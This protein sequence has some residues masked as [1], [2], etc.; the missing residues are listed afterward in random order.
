MSES[1]NTKA[2]APTLSGVAALWDAAAA[3]LDDDATDRPASS[4]TVV[5]DA[6]MSDL[7]LGDVVGY[8]RQPRSS[9]RENFICKVIELI[10]GEPDIWG[11]PTA[12]VRIAF[13]W[14]AYK[15]PCNNPAP[16]P[17]SVLVDSRSVIRLAR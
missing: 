16:L 13:V 14:K 9:T 15:I 11:H 7:Q 10:P 3:H 1:D 2:A 6:F 17:D 4:P 12:K 5:C 8:I